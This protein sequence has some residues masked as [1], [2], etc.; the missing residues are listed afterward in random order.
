M[1]GT[2]QEFYGINAL[3]TYTIT[4]TAKDSTDTNIGNGGDTFLIQISNQCTMSDAYNCDVVSGAKTTIPSTIYDKMTDNG[5]GTYSYSY[6]VKINGA[7]TILIKMATSNGLKSIFYSTTNWSGSPQLTTVLPNLNFIGPS[8]NYPSLS[9]IEYFTASFYSTIYSPTKETYTFYANID[10]SGQVIIDGVSKSNTLGTPVNPSVVF[11]AD[12]S[13]QNY[14]NFYYKYEQSC[15]GTWSV[16]EWSSPSTSRQ[17]IPTTYFYV[18][19]LVGSSPYQITVNWP[20][21]YTGSDPTSPTVWKEVWG[22]GI[23]VGTETC[24]DGNTVDGD[25]WQANWGLVTTGFVCAGGTIT[26]KDTWVKCTTGFYPNTSKTQWIT[27]WGDG[28]KAGSEG[29]DDGNTNDKDGWSSS[30]TV[31][32]GYKCSGGS[33]YSSDSWSKWDTGYYTNYSDTTQCITKWGDGFRKGSE[34]WDDGNLIDGDGW[35]SQWI[36]EDGYACVG[37]DLGVTDVWTQWD[38]GYDPNP[39]YSVWVGATVPLDAKSVAIASVT[40]ALTGVAANVLLSIFT[41]TSGGS[42]SSFGMM[43]QLQLV[44]LIPLLRTYLPTKIYNYLKSMNTSLFNIDFL[45]TSNSGSFIDFKGLFDFNQQNSYLK[46]LGLTSGS[47]LVNILNLTVTV[48]CILWLHIV[49]LIIYVI[50]RKAPRFRKIS[51]FLLKLLETLTF[52]FYI[53][54][55][56]ETYI[57]FILV[58]F[59]EIA[60]QNNWGI[61]NTRSCAMSYVILGFMIFFLLLTLWQWCKSR[62]PESFESQKY[63]RVLVDGMRPNWLCRSYFVAFIIRRSLFGVIL[64]FCQTLEMITRVVLF[65]VVQF[66]ITIYI[67]V[68][69]PQEEIKERISDVI[70]EVYYLFFGVFLLYFNTEARWSN[71][72]T[73]A[74]FWILMSNNFVLIL[75]MLSKY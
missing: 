70:N 21:G 65:V 7:I 42:T 57:L 17:V 75:I 11:T 68:L 37:G 26:V 56:W 74:Y 24:D 49:I 2:E 33:L 16:F 62:K 18:T 50:I 12:M 48:G 6:S 71:T 60:F 15:C 35:T 19:T 51:Q 66:L 5:D 23:K 44:I 27:Q 38:L 55:Y 13:T 36:V 29:C 9:T 67:I 8:Y 3:T 31:E 52:G 25:G 46:L 63:F 28:L 41:S 30:W 43:N 58:D 34:K 32:N 69:R 61:K 1:R 53:G 54:V 47:A 22:D 14:H 4:V 59:S 72:A 64:F 39:D 10:D 20:T 73:D 45:P 40:A